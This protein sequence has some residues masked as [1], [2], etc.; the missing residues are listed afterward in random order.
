[1]VVQFATGVELCTA[2]RAL[3]SLILLESH[4]KLANTADNQWD[5]GVAV[6][7]HR[8]FF[9]LVRFTL[10]MARITGIELI[11]TLEPERDD[12]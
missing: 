5:A 10:V 4:L 8:I 2:T 7:T 11:T 9:H 1:M 3:Q 12:I 6:R